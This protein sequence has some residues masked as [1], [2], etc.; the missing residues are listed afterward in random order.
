MGADALLARHDK[1][2]RLEHLRQGDARVL[3]HSANLD[4][5]LLAALATLFQTVANLA[6]GML[7][8]RLGTD[9][10]QI[11]H[12]A[13]DNATMRAG[14]SVRPDDAFKIFESLGFVVEM[15]AGKY[16]HCDCSLPVW[17]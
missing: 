3:E 11:V 8:G 9:T 6:L 7:L 1:V 13:T 4:G 15:G 16:R 14:D 2:N 17:L 12:T 5:E 10:G